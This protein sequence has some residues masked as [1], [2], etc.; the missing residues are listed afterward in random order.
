MPRYRMALARAAALGVSI[1]ALA[2]CGGSTRE[3][4]RTLALD[5]GAGL[6]FFAPAGHVRL[7][8]WDRDSLR[9]EGRLGAGE[10]FFFQ[11]DAR[12]AKFGAPPGAGVAR[13]Q[14]SEFTVYVPRTSTIAI[15]G[16]STVIEATD[17]SGYY[18][19]V[20]G[21]LRL[22][23]V[24]REA[25]LESVNGPIDVN[26]SAPWIRIRSAGGAVRVQGALEDV[27]VA[28]VTGDVTL[29]PTAPM[30]ARV[31]TMDGRVRYDG[32]LAARGMLD[33]DTHGGAVELRFVPSVSARLNVETM[34]GALVDSARGFARIVASPGGRLRSGTI[35]TRDAPEA[36]VK[37]LTF[38]G[39]VRL[40]APNDVTR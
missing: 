7:V 1:A 25:Q 16:A 3:V 13:A 24:V 29:S 38:S 34:S 37:V 4:T 6:K 8:G 26:C 39:E 18:Y 40:L 11:G 36:R 17:V 21:R 2:A 20:N 30:R 15:K 23:G 22:D 35:G 31:E 5:R 27:A 19:T 33:I 28:T 12:G 10:E 32:G 14:P 9:I